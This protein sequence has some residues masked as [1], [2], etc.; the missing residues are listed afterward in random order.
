MPTGGAAVAT[1]VALPTKESFHDHLNSLNS[2]HHL[3]GLEHGTGE[4]FL[5]TRTWLAYELPLPRCMGGVWLDDATFAITT[6]KMGR[7]PGSWLLKY[8][9]SMPLCRR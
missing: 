1:S 4:S 7:T 3:S 6:T 9:T 8:Q 5:Y 2:L